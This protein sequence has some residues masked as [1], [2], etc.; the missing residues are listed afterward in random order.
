MSEWPPIP[1]HVD[2]ALGPV[3]VEV[4][5]DLEDMGEFDPHARIIRVRAGMHPAAAWQAL[6]HER[7][8]LVIWDSGLKLP[9]KSE[10]YVCD[11]VGVAMA[12]DVRRRG[13]L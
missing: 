6:C 4:V 8:H 10:E 9:G 2:S 3:A 11:A 1:A 13:S 12:M 7:A 5:A